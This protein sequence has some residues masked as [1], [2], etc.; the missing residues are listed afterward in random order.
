MNTATTTVKW[1]SDDERMLNELTA[2]R[3]NIYTAARKELEDALMK[4][5]VVAGEL[6]AILSQPENA[7]EMRRLLKPFDLSTNK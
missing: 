2:R 3:Q 7:T 6:A 5:P 4:L 1:T